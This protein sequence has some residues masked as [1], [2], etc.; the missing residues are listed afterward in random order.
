MTIT[1]LNIA[2]QVGNR[3]DAGDDLRGELTHP[4]PTRTRGSETETETQG[5]EKRAGMEIYEL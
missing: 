2:P 1:I 3:V 4:P 5:Q